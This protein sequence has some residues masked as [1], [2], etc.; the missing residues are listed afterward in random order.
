MKL[1]ITVPW[2]ETQMQRVRQAFPQVEF[3]TTLT[4]EKIA[5]GVDDV[6][7]VFGDLSRKAFL[8]AKNLRWVQCHGAGVNKLV[9]IPELVA[10]DVTVTSTSGAHA[11][12]I[13]EQFFGTLLALTRKLPDLYLAQHRREWIDWGKWEEKV[14]SRPVGLQGMTLGIL[15][16]GNIGRAIAER[17]AAF[18]MRIV[19]ADAYDVSRPPYLAELWPVGQ[20]AGLLSQADVVAVTVPGT[21]ETSSLLN[22]ETLA[23]MK[24]GAYLGVV[25]R[26]GIVDEEAV[27][28]MLCAG[29]LAGAMFDVFKSEPLSQSSPLWNAPNLIITPHSSGKSEQTTAAAT[30]IFMENLRHYLA[31]EPLRNVVNKKAG[32]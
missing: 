24:S 13:A 21:P 9:G 23:L 12:T 17:G 7:V 4:E 25:S 31:G 3:I 1:L 8:Q 22:R 6:E 19:A 29:R 32:F 30:S 15:G 16:F 28:E 27:A 10:S 14:G 26:G 2:D 5:Q 11:A 20:I 18:A